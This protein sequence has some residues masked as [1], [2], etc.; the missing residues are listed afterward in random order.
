VFAE[1]LDHAAK[2]LAGSAKLTDDPQ[3]AKF[4]NMRADA[5]E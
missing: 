3:F 2:D 5:P 1:F 4:L